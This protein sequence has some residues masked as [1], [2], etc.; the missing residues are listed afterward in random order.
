MATITFNIEVPEDDMRDYL[1]DE[2]RQLPKDKLQDILLK[3]VEVLLLNEHDSKYSNRPSNILVTRNEVTTN[4]GYVDSKYEPT[5]LLRSVLNE[6]PT[7]EYLEPIVEEISNFI[8]EHYKDLVEEYIVNAFTNML[9][10][11]MDRYNLKR[12]IL[13]SIHT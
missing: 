9:F 7:K 8:K 4:Y 3:S 13:S 1:I 11:H 5:P 2:I 10:T 6:L 12:E